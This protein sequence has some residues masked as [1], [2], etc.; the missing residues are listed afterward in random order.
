MV[1]TPGV[2]WAPDTESQDEQ[3]A[4]WAA[5]VEKFHPALNRS[6]AD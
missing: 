1:H 6:K 5:V 3:E 2:G 4:C